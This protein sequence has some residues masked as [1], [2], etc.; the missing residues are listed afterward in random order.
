[1]VSTK[2]AGV[3][4]THSVGTAWHGRI[5]LV[6]TQIIGISALCFS[7]WLAVE[8]SGQHIL[9]AYSFRQTQT[10]LTSFWLC[11]TGFKFPYE[12]PAAGYPWSIPFEFPLYQYLVAKLS[13]PFGF[14]LE[15]VGRLVSYAFLVACL[16]P[17]RRATGLAPAVVL[18]ND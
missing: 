7:A 15:R 14:D 6:L 5:T 11:R 2:S 9:E 8:Y 4:T 13:C 3:S 1:M 16:V 10:A 18:R 12:T 17:A